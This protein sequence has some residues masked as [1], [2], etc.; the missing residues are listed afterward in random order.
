MFSKTGSVQLPILF[1]AILDTKKPMDD[2]GRVLN[3]E[4]IESYMKSS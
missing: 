1:N 2:I 4:V 3:E